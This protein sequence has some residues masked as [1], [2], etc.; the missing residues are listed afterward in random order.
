MHFLAVVAIYSNGDVELSDVSEPDNWD[1]LSTERLKTVRASSVR[2]LRAKLG[3]PY[4]N[5]TDYAVGVVTIDG[6]T[7]P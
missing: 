7:P 4:D 5:T 6:A 2:D 1:E 3:S